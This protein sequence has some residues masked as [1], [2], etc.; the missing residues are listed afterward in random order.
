MYMLDSLDMMQYEATT[1]KVALVTKVEKN[2]ENII[3]VCQLIPQRV[4]DVKNKSAEYSVFAPA[5]ADDYVFNFIKDKKERDWSAAKVT[6][7]EA[8]K[9]GVVDKDY[10]YHAKNQITTGKDK[11]VFLVELDS[12]KIKVIF[13]IKFVKG[14][15]NRGYQIHC[16][17]PHYWKVSFNFSD[18]PIN[19]LGQHNIIT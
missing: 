19:T 7:L 8:P 14:I 18:L 13:F 9:Y 15:G 4:I 12:Y 16:P 2:R 5:A 10:Y 6:L 11:A 17:E 3:G 1:T